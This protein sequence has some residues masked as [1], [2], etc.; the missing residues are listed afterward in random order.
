MRLNWNIFAGVKVFFRRGH[1]LH[2]T[3][4]PANRP[5]IRPFQFVRRPHR[6]LQSEGH[7]EVRPRQPGRGRADPPR[8]QV[9]VL[10][11][12]N[13]NCSRSNFSKTHA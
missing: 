9:S 3:S 1:G 10:T 2:G 7:N 6:R 11:K 4:L 12:M 13:V 5:K 8:H